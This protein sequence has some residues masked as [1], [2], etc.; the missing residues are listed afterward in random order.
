MVRKFFR[1]VGNGLAGLAHVI[2]SESMM[3]LHVAAALG[4]VVAGF[5]FGLSAL[6]WVAVV[7]C[8]GLMFSVECM[9]TALE[10][11]ANRVSL[12][13]HPLIKHAKDCASGAV[14]MLAI[15]SAV[16]GGIIFFPRLWALTGW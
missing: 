2:Q 6:E 14:L 7:F 5:A 16:V 11:L 12:E 8:I 1:G 3:R 15:M 10:R 9:N 4:V 13:L